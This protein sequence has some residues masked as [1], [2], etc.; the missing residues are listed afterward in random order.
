MLHASEEISYSLT[1]HFFWLLQ[2]SPV[3]ELEPERE[4]DDGMIEE[5]SAEQASKQ[6]LIVYSLQHGGHIK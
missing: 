1:A 6:W 5:N 3:T 4:G 2:L